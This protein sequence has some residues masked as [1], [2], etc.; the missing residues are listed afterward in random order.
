M[1][2]DAG[3]AEQS[4]AAASGFSAAFPVSSEAAVGTGHDLLPLYAAS[5]A[6]VSGLPLYLVG[7]P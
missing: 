5:K 4:A 7:T 1:G 2:G 3:G 6:G